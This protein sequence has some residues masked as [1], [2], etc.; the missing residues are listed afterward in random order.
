M[1]N[2]TADFTVYSDPLIKPKG[3]VPIKTNGM[4]LSQGKAEF[5]F[6]LYMDGYVKRLA[7]WLDSSEHNI[8]HEFLKKKM[9]L[10][11]SAAEEHWG[12]YKVVGDT[13]IVQSFNKH[14]EYFYKRWVFE[15]SLKILNDTT[16]K[17]FSTHS[18]W[19]KYPNTSPVIF[20]FYPTESKPDSTKSWFRE[21]NWFKK[22]LHES[23]KP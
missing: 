4:Y 15:D 11:I 1:L 3:K 5:P 6:I 7:V 14:S 22:G 8:A 10:P 9:S 16:L 12:Q 23:R 2:K 18:H 19:G 17:L 21:K 13:I 20:R